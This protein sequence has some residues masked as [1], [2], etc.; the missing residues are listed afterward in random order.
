[1]HLHDAD[2]TWLNQVQTSSPG[3]PEHVSTSFIEY[4]LPLVY[5]VINLNLSL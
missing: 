3:T 2:L 5:N 4:H 1:M